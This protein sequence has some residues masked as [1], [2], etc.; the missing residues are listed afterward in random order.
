MDRA[1]TAIRSGF[2]FMPPWTHGRP[3][4]FPP[5]QIM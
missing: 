4:W 3:G 1:L 5:E 2:I